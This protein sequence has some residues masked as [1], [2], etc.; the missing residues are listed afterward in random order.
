LERL[1]NGTTGRLVD[2]GTQAPQDGLIE[3]ARCGIRDPRLS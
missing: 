2:S 3:A 1:V